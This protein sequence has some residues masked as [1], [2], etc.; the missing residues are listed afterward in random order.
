MDEWQRVLATAV[1]RT[2]IDGGVALQLPAD[3]DTAAELGRLA[4]AEQECC[5]F[6]DFRLH[7]AGPVIEFEVRAPR[8]ASD[9]VTAMFGASE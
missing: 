3:P 4:A 9:L 1:A 6:F 2:A 5:S 7:L 8:N